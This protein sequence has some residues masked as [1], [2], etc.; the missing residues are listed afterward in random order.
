MKEDLILNYKLAGAGWSECTIIIGNRHATVTASYL[1]DALGDLADAVISIADGAKEAQAAFTEEPGTYLWK[2][3]QDG[4]DV[5]MEIHEYADWL[6]DDIEDEPSKL[7]IEGTCTRLAL[8]HAMV[9]CMKDVL[10]EYGFD[11]YLTKWIEH[12]FPIDKFNYLRSK[13]DE[14]QEKM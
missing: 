1:S 11:C 3:M 8:M 2:F 13:L 12:P 4:K 7:I 6:N 5:H 9:W 14:V 10:D